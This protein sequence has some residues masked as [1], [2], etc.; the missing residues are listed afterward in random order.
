MA[1]Q[2]EVDA[3]DVR[4]QLPVIRD[5]LVGQRDNQLGSLCASGFRL[6]GAQISMMG[7]KAISSPGE[8]RIFRL[9]RD[10]SEEADPEAI[11]SR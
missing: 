5:E 2:D 10:Q 7:A 3:L 9:R 1:P 8:E 4:S 6:L 11:L